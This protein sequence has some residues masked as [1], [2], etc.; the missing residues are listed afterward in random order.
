MYPTGCLCLVLRLHYGCL[1]NLFVCAMRIVCVD[2]DFLVFCPMHI[3]CADIKASIDIPPA[4]A[5]GKMHVELFR[6]AIP[7]DAV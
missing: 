6:S 2:T 5:I 3:V 7:V 4:E 1:I